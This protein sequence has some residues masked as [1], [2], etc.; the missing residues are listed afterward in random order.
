[1]IRRIGIASENSEMNVIGDYSPNWVAMPIQVEKVAISRMTP[2][3]T[4]SRALTIIFKLQG[5]DSS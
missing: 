3:I 2:P 4:T 5:T 1:M